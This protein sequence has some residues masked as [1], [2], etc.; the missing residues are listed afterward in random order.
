MNC[1][2]KDEH[3]KGKIKVY[4]ARFEGLD[5]KLDGGIYK[6]SHLCEF[7]AGDACG[8]FLNVLKGNWLEAQQTHGPVLQVTANLP[9][10][11]QTE[12]SREIR[13]R[14]PYES[15][16]IDHIEPCSECQGKTAMPETT[17]QDTWWQRF[18][19]AWSTYIP[20]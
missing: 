5:L 8:Q 13:K 12:R 14:S 16:N 1:A 18:K 3:C 19:N 20:D 10:D 7:H 2:H 6:T 4:R 17:K 11:S 9:L 15:P